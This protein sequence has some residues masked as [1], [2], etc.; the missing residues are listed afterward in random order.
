MALGWEKKIPAYPE[1]HD[2]GAR[3]FLLY[4]PG[5][6]T[7]TVHNSLSASNLVGVGASHPL[8]LGPTGRRAAPG[9]VCLTKCPQVP[10]SKPSLHLVPRC[11]EEF[12]FSSGSWEGVYVGPHRLSGLGMFSVHVHLPGLAE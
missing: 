1:S 11:Q 6:G 8:L 7:P 2:R 3:P 5:L 4:D 12:L 9:C 10:P